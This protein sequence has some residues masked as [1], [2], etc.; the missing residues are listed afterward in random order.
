LLCHYYTAL[1]GIGIGCIG[2]LGDKV[3]CFEIFFCFFLD[4]LPPDFLRGFFCL[5]P[6]VL[7]LLRLEEPN[8]F[9][10]MVRF[11][12]VFLLRVCLLPLERPFLCFFLFW[13]LTIRLFVF[14]RFDS[15]FVDF[16]DGFPEDIDLI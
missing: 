15:A 6:L 14:L 4:I 13:N 9:D 7:S 10:P 5:L 12:F 1:A 11:P 3:C 2:T 16:R 8:L